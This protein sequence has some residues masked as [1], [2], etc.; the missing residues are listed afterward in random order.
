LVT[1]IPGASAT[2]AALTT[3]GLPT[4]TFLFA[5]FPP[6]K[7][8]A[9]KSRLEELKEVPATLVLFEASS[10]LAKSLA[11]MAQVFGPREAAAAKELTK[12]HETLARGTL[13][14]LAT[15]FAKDEELKGEFV[16]VVAPPSADEG[17]LSDAEIVIELKEAMKRA[18][19]RD[20]VREVTE[21]HKLKRARVYQLGLKLG[22]DAE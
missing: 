18:S 19:F 22:R 12:L 13:G 15:E 2:L 4:D 9:R 20:A 21:A 14:Q 17:E 6:Q 1:S 11:D 7:S 10:R 16:I 5:G 8:G 3:S